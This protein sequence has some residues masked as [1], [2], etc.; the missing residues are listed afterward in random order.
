M[1]NRIPE[2]NIICPLLIN[3]QQAQEML[4]FFDYLHNATGIMIWQTVQK[5][6]MSQITTLRS[7]KAVLCLMLSQC[8]HAAPVCP[9]NQNFYYNMQACKR[10]CL[11]LSDPDPRCGLNDTSVE[12]CGC[13]EGTYLNEGNICTPK[14]ECPCHYKGGTTPPGAVVID[15]QQ[16][17][18]DDWSIS[19]HF[20]ML[21]NLLFWDILSPSG[22]AHP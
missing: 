13:P 4:L 10:T 2:K 8:C 18:A 19:G 20:K 17:W 11:Y 22:A 9:K 15:G 5:I 16:W 6:K 12:G 21:K 14:G 3:I 7:K 1:N